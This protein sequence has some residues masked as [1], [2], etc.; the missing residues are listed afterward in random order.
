[1]CW[2]PFHGLKRG[3]DFLRTRA[4]VAPILALLQPVAAASPWEFNSDFLRGVDRDADLSA[5]VGNGSVLPGTYPFDVFINGALIARARIEFT[6]A[7]G[8]QAEPCFDADQLTSWGIK[9]PERARPILDAAAPQPPKCL[10]LIHDIPQ[11]HASYNGNQQRIDLSIPQRYLASTPRGHIPLALRDD[12]IN[13]GF[14][15]YSVNGAHHRQSRYGS[16]AYFFGSLDSGINVGAWRVRH[17]ARVYQQHGASSVQWRTQSASVERDLP[18]LRSRM[19]LG[20]TYSG[21]MVFDSVQFRGGQLASDEEM[22]P[23]SRRSYAP[24]VQG[25]AS[26]NARVEI[27]QDGSLVYAANVAPGPFLIDDIVPSRMSGALEITVIEADGSTHHY[28]QPFSSVDTMLRPGLWR[29]EIN[30]GELQPGNTQYRPVFLQ[31]TLA[32]GLASDATPYGGI[33]LAAHYR[34]AALGFAKSLGDFGSLSLDVTTARAELASQSVQSGR[35]YRILYSKSLNNLGTEFRLVG[36][37][38]STSG[39]FDFSEAAAE[40]GLWRNGYYEHRY[41]HPDDDMGGASA[42]ATPRRRIYTERFQNKRSRLDVSVNQRLTDRLRLYASY[43]SQTYW[44]TNN[45][46][47]NVQIGL[48]GRTGSVTH[49]IFL[50]DTRAQFGYSDRMLGINISI[51]LGKPQNARVNAN[52]TY[53]HSRRAGNSYRTGVSGTALDDGRLSYG[54][55]AGHSDAAGNSSA[56]NVAYQHRAAVVSAGIAASDRYS[57]VQW[58]LSGSALV[59]RAG[60]TLSQ[61]LQRTVALVHAPD[62]VGVGL[63]NQSGVRIDSRGYA[64]IPSMSPYRFNRIALRTDDIGADIDL[65]KAA[66]Q[67]VPTRG[68]IVQVDFNTRRGR[69]FLINSNLPTGK[70]LPLGAS[71]FDENGLSRGVVGPNGQVFVSGVQHDERLSVRWGDAQES[72]CQLSLQ[73]LKPETA[74]ESPRSAFQTVKLSCVPVAS[75]LVGRS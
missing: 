9:L 75:S 31:T 54:L 49:G 35:S 40:R 8:G 28:R 53:V 73:E 7:D 64:V 44:G 30:A 58:G 2:R 52:S 19:L 46:E 32:K 11:S 39:Y 56:A 55:D 3:R 27:R 29:Y 21:N 70:P 22:L 18:R 14:V 17:S 42:W 45:T 57:Q 1:M 61:P 15:N 26:T 41:S 60:V 71:V 12:G 48:N 47:R 68:A 33:L 23:Y 43:N 16:S 50:R 69:N 65:S 6:R 38:Y 62:A 59:H 25:L 72:Q 34:A 63:E 51:P 13:A 4:W 5:F 24:I 10:A 66:T 20:D 36:H 37:R 67:V 74:H